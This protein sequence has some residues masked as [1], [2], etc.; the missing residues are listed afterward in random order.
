MGHTMFLDLLCAWRWNVGSVLQ[1]GD[2]F[3]R[4]FL[5]VHLAF[6]ERI[7]SGSKHIIIIIIIIP[8]DHDASA[9]AAD[10]LR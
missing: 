1:V 9:S 10:M 6:L 2:I 8:D 5:N 7:P 4:L 3:C